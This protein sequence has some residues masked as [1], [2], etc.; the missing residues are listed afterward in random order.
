MAKNSLLRMLD[1]PPCSVVAYDGHCRQ[2]L[3]YHAL[4]FHAVESKGAIAMQDQHLLAGTGE[5]RGH[6]ETCAR[7][8]ATHRAWIEPVARFIDID[9]S[10]AIADDIAAIAYNGGVLVDKVAYLAAQ[11]HGVNGYII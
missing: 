1:L 5:L 6:R 2:L 11:T 7:P 9:D 8:Q 10:P 4:E 3:A